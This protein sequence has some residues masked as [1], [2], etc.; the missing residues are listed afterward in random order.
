MQ[1][2]N[3]VRLAN[4]ESHSSYVSFFPNEIVEED[5]TNFFV[6]TDTK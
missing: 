4:R 3:I 6:K 2:G 5:S 1:N